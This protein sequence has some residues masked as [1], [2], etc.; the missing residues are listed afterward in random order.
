[1]SRGC[2]FNLFWENSCL[3]C[4]RHFNILIKKKLFS[5]SL[6]LFIYSVPASQGQRI[7]LSGGGSAHESHLSVS[8]K[9]INVQL[10]QYPKTHQQIAVEFT[11]QVNWNPEHDSSVLCCCRC[12]VPRLKHIV[13]T[14]IP[15]LSWLPHYS[16]RENAVSDLISGCSVGIMHL[17]Q[18]LYPYIYIYLHTQYINICTLVRP[19]S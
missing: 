8:Y 9:C 3:H 11:L 15:V 1:M 10:F 18:G 7:K 19:Q 13:R 16:I 2:Y 14:W 5:F 17:P 4:N 6:L 12:T